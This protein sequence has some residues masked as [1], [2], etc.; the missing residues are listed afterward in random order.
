MNPKIKTLA[1]IIL[2]VTLGIH[3]SFSQSAEELLPGAIQL[4]VVYGELEQ[5]I[6][7]YQA[8]IDKY[9]DNNPMPVARKK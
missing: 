1:I 7:A 9:P 4:E 3:N 6:D 5:A 2:G 8:I